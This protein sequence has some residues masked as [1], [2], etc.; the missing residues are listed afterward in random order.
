MSKALSKSLKMDLPALADLLR[1]K[2]RGK[3][4]ILAHIT[5]QEAALLKRR[6]G[7]GSTNPDTGLPEFEDSGS[8][9]FSTP[10]PVSPTYDVVSGSGAQQTFTP[11]Q[12]DTGVPIQ[13]G[14][15]Y[16]PGGDAYAPAVSPG[17][18]AGYDVLD[19]F[20]QTTPYGLPA[21]GTKVSDLQQIG[22][23]T[24]TLTPSSP[25]PGVVSPDQQ[26]A[27]TPKTDQQSALDKLGLTGKDLTR[28][29]LGALLT[30]GLA[31]TN[32]SRTRQAQQQANQAQAQ[33]QALATPYQQQ[34]QQLISQAQAGQLSPQSQAAY[35]AAQARINQGIANRGGVGVQ[36]ASNELAN[37]YQSLLANQYQLGQQVL[38]IG[39]Q[40]ALGAIKT[41]LQADQAIN[42]ANQNFYQALAQMAAPFLMGQ[43]PVYQLPNTTGVNK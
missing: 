7:S 14:P 17:G 28:M 11:T 39:D 8:Y 3:D 15:S 1:S 40:Y 24:P 38:N 33:Q 34:G 22:P 5:P 27:V 35:Q 13:V 43:Q 6:G 23:A 29:G 9:D 36:Q 16:Q 2:G 42:Q 30:G 31:A 20:K 18:N 32:I 41:G 10:A 4:T 12:A 25:V 21:G 19:Q 37:I 26:A